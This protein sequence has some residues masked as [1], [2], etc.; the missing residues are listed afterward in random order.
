MRKAWRAYILMHVGLAVLAAAFVLYAQ[1][2]RLFPS[3]TFHCAMHDLLHLYCPFCGGTRGVRA[4]LSLQ[5]VQALHLCGGLI[6]AAVAALVLDLRAL[7]LLCRG[8][9]HGLLPRALPRVAVAY[10]LLLALV[11][12][13]LLLFGIDPAGDLLPW[14]QARISPLLALGF[15]FLALILCVLLLIALDAVPVGFVPRAVAGFGA[16]AVL[17]LI[18]ALLYSPWLLLGLLPV[19]AAAIWMI[20]KR[21]EA[22]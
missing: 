15:F 4:L 12:N 2:M 5:F 22:P 8:R 1:I 11:R 13:T 10:F 19:A 7:V 3:D 9:S 20:K 17:V 6:L 21:R 14:W 16:G 18:C